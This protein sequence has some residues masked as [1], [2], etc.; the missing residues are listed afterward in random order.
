MSA[1]PSRLDPRWRD[2]ATGKI[3]PKWQSLA[4]KMM[5]MRVIGETKANPSPATVVKCAGEIYDFFAK[6]AAAAPADLAA[7]LR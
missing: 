6:N 1:V 7:I 3:A 4:V 2:V 5:M